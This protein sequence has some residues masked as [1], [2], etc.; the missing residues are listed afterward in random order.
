MMGTSPYFPRFHF[1]RGANPGR[2]IAAAQRA[3]D[4]LRGRGDQPSLALACS[5]AAL[6]L[7]LADRSREARRAADEAI[8]AAR[9]SGIG[10]VVAMALYAKSF[11]ADS[12]SF[13]ERIG[14]LTEAFEMSDATDLPYGRATVHCTYRRSRLSNSGDLLGCVVVRKLCS[15]TQMWTELFLQ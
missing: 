15:C 1:Y 13:A 10:P 2:F 11:A 14:L 7:R 3:S 12:K 9:E 6:H 8:T 4:L 5:M